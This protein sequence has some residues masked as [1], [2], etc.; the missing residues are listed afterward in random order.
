MV[1]SSLF[2]WEAIT[3]DIVAGLRE[4]NT[5]SHGCLGIYT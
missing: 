1:L 2:W 4:E 5:L 3:V